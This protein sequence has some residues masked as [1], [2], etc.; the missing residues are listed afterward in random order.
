V[1]SERE[2]MKSL[3]GRGFNATI[4][5]SSNEAID[6]LWSMS[7]KYVLLL[8]TVPER[9]IDDSTKESKFF[10]FSSKLSPNNP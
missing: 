3:K 6:K 9:T 8:M 4:L 10:F 2:V 1:L 5:S 7:S